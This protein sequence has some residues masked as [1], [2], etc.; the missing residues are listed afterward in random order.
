MATGDAT[1]PF[2]VLQALAESNFC[3][4]SSAASRRRV[5][6]SRNRNTDS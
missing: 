4:R 1:W 5:T 6:W 3:V 2:G